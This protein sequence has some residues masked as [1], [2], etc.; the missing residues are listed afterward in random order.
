MLTPYDHFLNTRRAK[1]RQIARATRGESTLA[2]VEQSAWLLAYEL[3]EQRG[4]ALDLSNPEDQGFLVRRLYNRLVKYT[5]RLVRHALRVDEDPG[6]EEAGSGATIARLL[7]ASSNSDPAVALLREE[8]TKAAES[9]IVRSY[10]EAAAYLV[11]L[12]RF[13]WNVQALAEA[14]WIVS[15]TL[16]Q[17]IDRAIDVVNVQ[18]SLFDGMAVIEPD[19]RAVPVTGRARGRT[20]LE[21]ESQ[22]AL[23]FS[24]SYRH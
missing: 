7:A 1:L 11:L 15:G 24:V 2:D 20:H 13:K 14:L 8:T 22:L 6:E 16:R 10:S 9:A 12:R 17:R 21:S 4:Y 3:G 5:E 19:L 23:E 18:R